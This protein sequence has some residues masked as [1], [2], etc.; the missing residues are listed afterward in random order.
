MAA[1]TADP[2]DISDEGKPSAKVGGSKKL[3]M[4]GGLVALLAAGGGGFFYYQK[5]KSD[6]AQNTPVK[7]VPFFFD[8]PEMTANLAMQPGQERPIFLRIK[9]S[10][11]LEDQKLVAQITPLL[12]RVIDNFQVYLRE[13]HPSDLE[14]SVGIYRLREELVRRVNAAVYPAKI[15]AILFKDVLIQ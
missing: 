6:A 8:L 7:K 2:D 10:L 12:P 1:K 9:V 13:L 15:E 14:G 11:E 5:S 3:M 4:I